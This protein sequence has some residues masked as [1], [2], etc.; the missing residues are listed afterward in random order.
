M[1]PSYDKESIVVASLTGV[2]GEP[3]TMI[4]LCPDAWETEHLPPKDGLR[5]EGRELPGNI[6]LVAP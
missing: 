5:L 2:R 4:P 3:P 6:S 1:L